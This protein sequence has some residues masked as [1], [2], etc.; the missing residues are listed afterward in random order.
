[1]EKLEWWFCY[2]KEAAAR[3]VT[4]SKLVA[5]LQKSDADPVKCQYEERMASGINFY[6]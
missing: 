4:G 3:A 5:Q 2:R 1:M 6:S